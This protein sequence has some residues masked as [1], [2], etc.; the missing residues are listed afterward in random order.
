MPQLVVNM[1]VKTQ[2]KDCRNLKNFRFKMRHAPYLNRYAPVEK[3]NSKKRK[4]I[5]T[6]Y[7]FPNKETR[8]FVGL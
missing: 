4:Y 3:T 8:I 6:K 5:F 1:K 2:N 7:L